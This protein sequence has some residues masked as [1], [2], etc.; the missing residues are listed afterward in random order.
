MRIIT[1]PRLL[2]GLL[3]AVIAALSGSAS[4]AQPDE[5]LSKKIEK[6]D[7]RLVKA[8]VELAK[9]YDELKDPE[10]AH[11]LAECAV[12]FGSKDEKV[13][14]IKNSWE[15]SVYLGKLRGGV[16]MP[17]PKPIFAMLGGLDGEY[18]KIIDPL[19]AQARKDGIS[20]ETKKVLHECAIKHELARGAH[21][22]IQATQRFN[23]LRR[24]MGLRAVLWEFEAS[25]K[26]ISA[27]WY[28]SQTGDVDLDPKYEQTRLSSFYHTPGAEVAKK[29]TSRLVGEGLKDQPEHLRS[30][31]HVRADL[32]N[33]NAR[34]LHLASW[35]GGRIFNPITLYTIPQLPY[36]SDIPTPT[37]RFSDETLVKGLSDWVDTEDTF[38]ANGK[39][40]PFARY[41]YE[42]EPDA[43]F[44]YSKA[45]E[46][47]WARS[48][49]QF[50]E[51][52]GVPIMVRFF[53]D[54]STSDIEAELK[55]KSGTPWP[56]RIYNDGDKRLVGH[57]R[58]PM[59]L[60]LPEKPLKP[61]TDYTVKVKCSLNGSVFEKSWSFKTR[62]E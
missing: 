50:L 26:Y 6:L 39:R 27:A 46:S 40:I 4:F 28:M 54:G 20:E 14:A 36:R 12:G 51:K 38:L 55:D 2:Q 24:S 62:A 21:E 42:G 52:A 60:L 48:E 17:D 35:I 11:F 57:D 33:P 1:M 30:F 56:L 44:S 53:T 61:R 59:V 8:F 34:R 3:I 10:A 47:G 29:W 13:V 41:P 25:T 22:Y 16:V 15:A 9:Q 18:M 23:A 37:Q 31:A 49:G 19:V 5:K 58:W 32:L 7:A 45:G 43:P